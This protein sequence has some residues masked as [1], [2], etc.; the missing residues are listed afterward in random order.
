MSG[1]SLVWAIGAEEIIPA[2]IAIV[3][4]LVS[5]ISQYL[6]KMR[7][8][9]RPAG[10]PPQRPVVAAPPQQ[11]PGEGPA[12]EDEIGEFL[13]RTAR[14]RGP[15][16]AQ[17][18]PQPALEPVLV[19]PELAGPVG[20]QVE[21]HVKD[22]LNAGEF[23][24]R[25]AQLGDEVAQADEQ[26]GQHLHQVFDHNVSSL[27]AKPG[28]VSAQPAVVVGPAADVA[29]IELPVSA[30]AGFAAL[31]SD[32]ENVRQAIVINEILRRP[33]ERWR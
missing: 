31:L 2:I 6:G 10:G 25:S 3:I 29:A 13:R 19:E 28:D 12:M 5:G 18:D 24:R 26:L 14:R 33:E 27:A 23:S 9:Q 1:E 21:E 7:Q 20:G 15:Q 4:M 32:M 8:P 22:F 11:A 16:A 30:A 17:P